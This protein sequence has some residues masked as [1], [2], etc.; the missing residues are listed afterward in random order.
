MSELQESHQE[1]EGDVDINV[2]GDVDGEM[3]V[4]KGN[5]VITKNI[6]AR[7]P[8][9]TSLWGRVILVA[10]MLAGAILIAFAF[11]LP[12]KA[13]LIKPFKP[14]AE[15][16]VLVIVTDFAGDKGISAARRIYEALTDRVVA[17]DLK[18]TRIEWLRGT[19]PESSKEAISLG[20]PFGATLVVWGI[21]DSISIEPHYEILRNKEAIET[22]A[23]LGYI[24]VTDL[25]TFTAYVAQDAPNEFEYLMLFCLGQIAYYHGDY[26]SACPLFDQ[27]VQVDVNPVRSPALGLGDA[28]IFQG[29]CAQKLGS[30]P[31]KAIASY[32]HA[33][34]VDPQAAIA[35]FN[36]GRAYGYQGNY[37]AALADLN[38]AIDL[39]PQYIEAYNNRGALYYYVQGNYE[40]ALA[41]FNKAFEIDPQDAYA[42]GGRGALYYLQG[43]YE[44]A[45]ADFNKAIEIDPKDVYAYHDRALT[46]EKLGNRTAALSDYTQFMRLYKIEDDVSTFVQER[47]KA[48]GGE[49]P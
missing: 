13:G 1:P 27:A 45:L 49:V 30:T 31:Q 47:I 9:P 37:Q 8:L 17:S 5:V 48:L 44:A 35:Y 18:S 32:D 11:G 6:I 14:A 4:A 36:R 3:I 7:L 12:Q 21:A 38:K 23:D 34:E 16:E 20:E 22:R 39:D 29:D 40:A 15:G 19:I 46:Y 25:P 33:V 26:S 28:Y 10:G 42:Y 43:K 41:D 2:T 24:P